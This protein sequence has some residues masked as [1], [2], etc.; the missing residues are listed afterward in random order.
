MNKY[1]IR[2]TRLVNSPEYIGDCVA[3]IIP[4]HL[5]P[6]VL[7]ITVDLTAHCAIYWKQRPHKRDAQKIG[8]RMDDGSPVRI[9]HCLARRDEYGRFQHGYIGTVD[10]L[11]KSRLARVIRYR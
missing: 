1:N 3:G 7:E 9:T 6:D 5:S 2:V 10:D 11:I 4:A 8:Y